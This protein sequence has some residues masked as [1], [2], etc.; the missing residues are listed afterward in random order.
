MG[1]HSGNPEPPPEPPPVPPGREPGPQHHPLDRVV[2]AAA[3]AVGTG[4][5]MAWAGAST[6]AALLGA[7]GSAAVVVLA[8]WLARTTPGPPTPRPPGNRHRSDPQEREP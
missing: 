4:A 1:R 2:L 7:I 8:A 6:T 5:V 3:A